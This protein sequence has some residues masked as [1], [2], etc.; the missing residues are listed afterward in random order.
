M[1]QGG[2]NRQDEARVVSLR[3]EGEDAAASLPSLLAEADRIAA[4]VA[5]GVHGRRRSG[6]GETFWQYRH[7]RPED[8]R[9]AIDWRQSARSD[10]LFVRQ[11]EWEAAN[12][13][14]LW[15]DGSASMRYTSSRNHG[16]KIDRAAVCQIAVAALLTQGGERVS[17][18][19]ES[20][21][22]RTGA[23]GLERASRRLALGPG[24]AA[25][26]EAPNI[27]RFGRVVLASDFLDPIET[28]TARLSRFAAMEAQ[29][30]MLR[31]IDPAE[32]DFPYAGRTRFEHPGGGDS[33]LFGRAEEARSAYRQRWAEHGARLADLAR[34]YGWTLVTHRTDRPATSAVLALYRALAR[35]V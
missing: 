1:S 26:V 27:S 25:S 5:Q 7:H 12:T 17:V 23:L 30:V 6:I 19:G 22:A 28:W 20:A 29:G 4:T 32:E 24:D 8:G 21:I 15:R 35:E 34:Q 3:H 14:W 13:I 9:Q 18:L 10:Q 33:L 11:N 2:G 16:A 31:V